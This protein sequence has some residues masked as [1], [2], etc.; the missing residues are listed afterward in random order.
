MH[1]LWPNVHKE[2]ARLTVSLFQMRLCTVCKLDLGTVFVRF[3]MIFPYISRRAFRDSKGSWFETLEA[4]VTNI[5]EA[6]GE[7]PIADSRA[8]LGRTAN[9]AARAGA[10]P[11]RPRVQRG[12][13]SVPDD[14][15][16]PGLPGDYSGQSLSCKRM[17]RFI[18]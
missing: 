15:L 12:E 4:K 2:N 9:G 17:L 7:D 3:S 6:F 5:E 16:E 10:V 11:D 18:N 14:L 1:T 8:S 13:G